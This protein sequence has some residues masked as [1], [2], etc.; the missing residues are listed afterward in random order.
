MAAQLGLDPGAVG[1]KATSPEGVGSLGRA[2]GIAAQA[3]A[4]IDESA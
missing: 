4:L 2:E 3:V 1:V